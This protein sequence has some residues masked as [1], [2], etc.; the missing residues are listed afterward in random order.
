MAVRH[1]GPAG[2]RSLLG[3]HLIEQR[4]QR[5]EAGLPVLAERLGPERRFLERRGLQAAEMLPAFDAAPDEL[6]VL[7]HAH[8]LVAAGK[9][10]FRGAASSLR[11]RSPPESCRMMA[12]RAGWARA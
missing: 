7:Q 3:L 2:T 11:L 8:V 12:R 5:F 1:S 4:V 10:I 9:V 6:G